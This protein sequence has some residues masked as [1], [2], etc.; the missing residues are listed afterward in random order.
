MQTS[1]GQSGSATSLCWATRRAVSGKSGHAL[2][3]AVA[4]LKAGPRVATIGSRLSPAKFHPLLN[5][6][7][8]WARRTGLDLHSS[9]LL[10]SSLARPCRSP[11]TN[12]E[13]QHHGRGECRLS[14]L[15]SSLSSPGRDSYLKC[16]GAL[17]GRYPGDA[18]HDSFPRLP[19]SWDRLTPR[20]M[21]DRQSHYAEMVA[22]PGASAASSRR[23]H[24]WIVVR[25]GCRCWDRATAARRRCLKDLSFRLGF[26]S[27]DG[28]AERV[29]TASFF[30]AG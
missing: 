20:P 12:H 23:Q 19:T 16:V 13:F 2:H 24:D 14:G 11:T 18:D 25:N 6:R 17:D 1:Q 28:F 22:I 5:N 8:T 30:R 9:A 10:A 29:F 15:L 26:R 7:R 3:I 4:L 21:P 27:I